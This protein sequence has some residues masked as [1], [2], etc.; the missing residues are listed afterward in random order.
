MRGVL[1]ALPGAIAPH[2]EQ[3]AQDLAAS[4]REAHVRVRTAARGE[5][6]GD[7]GVRGLTVRPQLPV[8]VLG[9]YLYQPGGNR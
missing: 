6:A 7:L 9:V 3:F 1:A 8:D 2:L 5:R 4:L